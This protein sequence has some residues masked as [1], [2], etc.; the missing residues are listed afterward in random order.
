M[1]ES[2]EI[3]LE[4]VK[5]KLKQYFNYDDFKNKIQEKSILAI[6]NGKYLHT[7]NGGLPITPDMT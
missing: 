1:D 7:P 4:E 5:T 2:K 6:L 3:T